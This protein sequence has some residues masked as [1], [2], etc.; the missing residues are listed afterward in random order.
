M[1]LGE[2][3][4]APRCHTDVRRAPRATWCPTSNHCAAPASR[5]GRGLVLAWAEASGH[6]GDRLPM[7]TLAAT[8]GH[9]PS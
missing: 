8:T 2:E 6:L 4:R 7:T 5:P 1:T 9:A 3:R